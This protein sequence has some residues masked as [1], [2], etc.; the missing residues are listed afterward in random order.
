MKDEAL[1]LADWLEDGEVEKYDIDEASAMIRRLVEELDKQNPSVFNTLTC[2]CKSEFMGFPSEWDG[3]TRECEPCVNYGSLCEQH[4]MEYEARPAQYTPQTKPLSD[5]EKEK[6][7]IRVLAN[8]D[9]EQSHLTSNEIISQPVAWMIID[10]DNGKSLQ[11]K[12]NKFSEINIP[13]YTA[14]KE[15]SD[16]EL[17]KAFDYYCETDE[18][19]L[20]F[21][22]ELR[23]EWKKEQLSRWKESFKKA[24]EI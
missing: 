13:L 22:Y 6:A 11:F 3:E 14:P 17:N 24:R 16:E 7:K 12:E 8:P 21:N 2:G 1:K 15:L 10:V 9:V 18:G 4:F 5:E 19:V 23:D 20:R